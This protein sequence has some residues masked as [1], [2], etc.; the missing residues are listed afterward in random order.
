MGLV[1]GVLM[2]ID[3]NRIIINEAEKEAVVEVITCKM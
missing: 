3:Y 2:L 1:E